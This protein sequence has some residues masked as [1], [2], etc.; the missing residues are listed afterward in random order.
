MLKKRQDYRE[1]TKNALVF[2]DMP[3]EKSSKK[4]RGKKTE[5]YVSDS[6]GSDAGNPDDV[7]REKGKKRRKR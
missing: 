7:P 4:G 3:S 2:A 1:K 6:G 5:Q